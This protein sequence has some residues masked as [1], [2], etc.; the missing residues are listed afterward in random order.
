[1]P[2]FTSPWLVQC[3]QRFFKVGKLCDDPLYGSRSNETVGF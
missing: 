3:P 2:T 1:M